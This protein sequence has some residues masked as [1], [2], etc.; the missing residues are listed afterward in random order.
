MKL[1]KQRPPREKLRGAFCDDQFYPKAGF[2]RE[3]MNWKQLANKG[4]KLNLFGGGRNNHWAHGCQ[5][6]QCGMY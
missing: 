5:E 1:C 2:L 4:Q 6:L 3:I